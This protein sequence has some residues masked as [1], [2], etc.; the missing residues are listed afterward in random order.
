MLDWKD[1]AELVEALEKRGVKWPLGAFAPG[2]Y[3][4][5]CLRCGDQFIGDKRATSCLE[6]AIVSSLVTPVS[7]EYVVKRLRQSL[8]DATGADEWHKFGEGYVG[9]REDVKKLAK[10]LEGG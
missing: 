5:K 7:A 1:S 3:I 8:I 10:E 6:C 9:L 4:A 2:N